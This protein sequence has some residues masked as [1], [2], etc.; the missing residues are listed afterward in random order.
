MRPDVKVLPGPPRSRLVG[1]ERHEE[2]VVPWSA[3]CSTGSCLWT[4]TNVIKTD[5]EEQARRHR[6]DHRMRGS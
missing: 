2:I 4:Y 3:V 5:V 6:A 1:N